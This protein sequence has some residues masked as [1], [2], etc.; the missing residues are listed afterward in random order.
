[1][2]LFLALWLPSL[3]GLIAG[4]IGTLAFRWA[5]AREV[6]SLSFS[7][8]DLEERLLR[9]IKKQAGDVGRE[10]QAHEK[11]LEEWA[12]QQPAVPVPT[13]QTQQTDLEKWRR[14]HM[15]S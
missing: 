3:C 6:R 8:A 13:Q 12:A 5:L 4:I 14:K 15:A 11:K 9:S 2:D 7:V 1:M 10:K